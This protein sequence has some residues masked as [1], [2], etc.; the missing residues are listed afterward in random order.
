MRFHALT[1]EVAS[2]MGKR[3]WLDP[4]RVEV[5]PRG[6][7]RS[8]VGSFSA[9][10]RNRVRNVLGVG[11]RPL[12]VAAARHE[13]QKGLD[14]LLRAWPGISAAHP[15]AVLLIGGREGQT[16]EHLHTLATQVGL[17]PATV[18]LGS[19]NDIPDLM[20]AADAFCVPSRWEGLG[21]ILIEAMALGAPVVASD[22]PPFR[23]LDPRGGWITYFERDNTKDLARQIAVTLARTNGQQRRA[24]ASDS[25]ESTYRAD[26]IAARMVEFFEAALEV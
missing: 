9:S 23:E 11:D 17:D 7:D 26:L 13:W 1:H 18:F 10:R 8:D 16:T 25:F 20:C 24:T 5:I 22:L 15:D 12:V 14:L 19:R 6:R 21:S 4:G 2:V 3:L